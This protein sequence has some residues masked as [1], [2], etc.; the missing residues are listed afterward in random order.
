MHELYRSNFN[1]ADV[2]NKMATG[3]NSI[4]KQIGVKVWWKRA[5]FGFVS[6]CETNAYL[7]YNFVTGDKME[8]PTFKE[9]LAW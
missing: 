3:P 5:F 6:L 9:R 1:A 7:A 8:R 4:A 2:F